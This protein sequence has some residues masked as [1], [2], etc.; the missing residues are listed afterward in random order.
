M[1][2]L[3]CLFER[4]GPPSYG[5]PAALAELYGGDFGLARPGL[6]ANFVSSVDGVVA[7]PDG[8]ESGGVISGD[9]SPDRFIM[10]LLRATADAVLIG[11][12]TFRKADGDRWY[13]E[14]IYPKASNHFADL[15]H[16]LGLQPHPV[17]VIVTASGHLDTTQIALDNSLVITDDAR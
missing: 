16:Q 3:E 4:E 17:L 5:L 6:Y 8:R 9:D 13:P 12:G 10:G 1:S 14:T 11:A 2:P 7:L 15:R